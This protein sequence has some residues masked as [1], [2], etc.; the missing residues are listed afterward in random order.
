MLSCR[1]DYFLLSYHAYYFLLSAYLKGL[2][3][4]YR[5]I[6][7]KITFNTFNFG[8]HEHSYLM[9]YISTF[10]RNFFNLYFFFFFMYCY[11]SFLLLLVLLQNVILLIYT[12]DTKQSQIL[13]LSNNMFLCINRILILSFVLGPNFIL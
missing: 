13:A 8:E 5:K 10:E 7:N 12:L 3:Q 6:I 1:P 11:L 9:V 4:N 2:S